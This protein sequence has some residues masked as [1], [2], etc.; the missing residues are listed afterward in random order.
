[1]FA[2]GLEIAQGID[3]AKSTLSTIIQAKERY[4]LI[5][6]IVND[7]PAYRRR[8]AAL[9]DVLKQ[10][11]SVFSESLDILNA[12]KEMRQSLVQGL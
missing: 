5:D 9:E 4:A 2:A 8:L 7:A 11:Q 10:V 12:D 1:M 6:G 3:S